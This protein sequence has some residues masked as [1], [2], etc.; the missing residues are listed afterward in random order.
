MTAAPRRTMSWPCSVIRTQIAVVEPGERPRRGGSRRSLR[1]SGRREVRRGRRA[2]SPTGRARRRRARARCRAAPPHRARI[3]LASGCRVGRIGVERVEPGGEPGHGEPGLE[4]SD[5]AAGAARTAVGAD[6]DVADLARGEA[7][8][9]SRA[10]PPTRRPAPTPRPT[11]TSSTSS[12]VPPKVY[13][14]STAALASFATSTGSPSAVVQARLQVEVGP[15]E[16]GRASDH[17][18]RVDDAG[19]ADADAEHR[20][21]RRSRR[22]GGRGRPRAPRPRRR[23]RRR[24]RPRRA[25]TMPPSRSRTAPRKRC[26][27]ERSTPTMRKRGAVDVDEHGGLAGAGRPRAGPARSTKP[28]AMRPATRSEIV[29]RVRPVSRATSARLCAPEV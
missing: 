8:R 21:R 1:A 13:S 2:R 25:T 10:G 23:W 19:R 17:A 7:R 5:L 14:A 22:A 20:G 26:C 6:G 27:S 3:S 9:R 24:G 28:S 16:V 4:A 12:L 11:L 29:T 15:A 18:E